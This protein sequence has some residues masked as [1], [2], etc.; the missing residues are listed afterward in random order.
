MSLRADLPRGSSLKVVLKAQGGASWGV[1][2]LL[3]TATCWTVGPFDSA[4]QQQEFNIPNS[5]NA[6]PCDLE[7]AMMPPGFNSRDM[8]PI[9]S[10]VIVDY[11]ENF[12]IRGTSA[13]AKSKSFCGDPP[14]ID[15]GVRPDVGTVQSPPDSSIY[16]ASTGDAGMPRDAPAVADVHED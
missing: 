8:N 11:Y 10:C 16:D 1:G 9:K 2:A 12:E 3:G 4:K 5:A 6:P 7:F 13:P 15:G 14:W